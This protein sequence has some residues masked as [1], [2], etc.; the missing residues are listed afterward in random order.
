MNIPVDPL[1]GTA[2]PDEG[3]IHAT[4]K[5]PLK[6]CIRTL[7]AGGVRIMGVCPGVDLP[8]AAPVDGV[9]CGR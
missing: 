8:H 1:R 5:R 3:D 2:G 9:G 6:A 4:G 7:H